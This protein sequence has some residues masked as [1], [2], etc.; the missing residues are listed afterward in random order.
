MSLNEVLKVILFLLSSFGLITTGGIQTKRQI[1]LEM[2]RFVINQ[3]TAVDC[4]TAGDLA[5]AGAGCLCSA[6]APY[7]VT[8][9]LQHRLTVT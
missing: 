9:A 4:S 3:W 2:T 1:I 6:A 8:V 5:S 7:K